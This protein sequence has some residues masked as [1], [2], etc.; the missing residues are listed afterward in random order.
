MSPDPIQ[1]REESIFAIAERWATGIEPTLPRISHF[2]IQPPFSLAPRQI[3]LTALPQSG[4]DREIQIGNVRK[5]HFTSMTSGGFFPSSSVRNRT[6]LLS[7]RR[8]VT[9]RAGF[10]LTLR[11]RIPR[12]FT[13]GLRQRRDCGDVCVSIR[14]LCGA[15]I[16][17]FLLATRFR[18]KLSCSTR[19]YVHW[20]RWRGD[21]PWEG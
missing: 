6:R 1:L 2:A 18:G 17:A 15:G 9:E 7:S 3:V 21:F 4:V 11:L 10:E 13:I 20:M 14:S 19:Q 16:C 5:G 12:R 8:C